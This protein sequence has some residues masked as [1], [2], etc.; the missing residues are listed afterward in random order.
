MEPA[1]LLQ[2][3][4]YKVLEILR[5]DAA[6]ISLLDVESQTMPIAAQVNMPADLL[7]GR[8]GQGLLEGMAGEVALTGEPRTHD[9][10]AQAEPADHDAPGSWAAAPLKAHDRTLGVLEVYRVAGPTFDAQAVHLLAT[11]GIQIGIAYQHAWLWKE[12]EANLE[13]QRQLQL[14][15]ER[16]A[17]ELATLYDVGQRIGRSLELQPVLEAMVDAACR[18]VHAEKA[19]LVLFDERTCRLEARASRG[20]RD[21]TVQGLTFEVR[22]HLV[23]SM[24]KADRDVLI[25]D[26][27]NQDDVDGD[28]YE[29]EGVRSLLRVPIYRNERVI[30]ELG[31]YSKTS[32]TFSQMHQQLLSTLATQATAAIEHAQLYQREQHRADQFRVANEL[33]RRLTSIL[34]SELLLWEVVELLSQRFQYYYVII[35]LMDDDKL[36]IQ[37]A[38]ARDSGRDSAMLG[39]NM[40]SPERGLIAWVAKHGETLR[41]PDVASEPRYLRTESLT[42]IRSALVAPLHGRDGVLGVLD[43]ESDRLDD[44][45]SGDEALLEAIAA[46]VSVALENAQLYAKTREMGILEERNRLAR[47]IHD[48]L[49][50]GFTGIVLQLEAAE[51]AMQANDADALNH[52]ERARHLARESLSEARRSVWDLRPSS[53][54]RVGLIQAI[55]REVDRFVEMT[56]GTVGTQFTH[57]NKNYRASVAVETALLRIVREALENVRK[58]A[59]AHAVEVALSLVDGVIA[60]RITDDGVGMHNSPS[61]PVGSGFGLVSM[62]ERMQLVGGSCTVRSELGK[63]TSVEVTA[64]ILP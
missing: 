13:A 43:I 48:T 47:E 45:D 34:D 17:A 3:T 36:T 37:A 44:F 56:G 27:A 26:L 41:V 16:R 23:D 15:L 24:R 64:P 63:G 50:Q 18:L 14:Q 6:A 28:L 20:L 22:A 38:Y 54:E 19:T 39:L 52:V 51:Q 12:M 35:A 46:Q 57:A 53:L 59:H 31:V 60:L 8:V 33:A 62:R 40:R 42:L 9:D 55:E 29:A 1:R 49:A 4:L 61:Q 11:V 5:C 32:N 25:A 58:H 21:E 7:A 10:Q 2:A 30:G